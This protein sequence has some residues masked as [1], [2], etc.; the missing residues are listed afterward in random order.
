MTFL[1]V[2]LLGRFQPPHR[3]HLQALRRAARRYEAVFVGIGSSQLSHTPDNPFTC[4]ERV[5]LLRA[6]L[7][8]R[9]PR[10]VFLYPVPDLRRHAAWVAHVEHLVPPF[11]VVITHN[12]LTRRLFRAAGYRVEPAPLWNRDEWSGRTV[13]QRIREGTSVDDLLTPPVRRRLEELEG[14]SRIRRLGGTRHAR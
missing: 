1:R 2:L 10:N 3:G 7:G 13:R 12:P 4:G 6:G 14:F 8:P 11:D 5:E 9:A